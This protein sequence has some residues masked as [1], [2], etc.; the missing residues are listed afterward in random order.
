MHAYIWN[1]WDSDIR[2]QTWDKM[3]NRNACTNCKNGQAIQQFSVCFFFLMLTKEATSFLHLLVFC[4]MSAPDNHT[5]EDL[6]QPGHRGPLCTFLAETLHHHSSP[7]SS[8][9]S[10]GV[11]QELIG[12]PSQLAQESTVDQMSH[13]PRT[14]LLAFR[15][16]DSG[17]MGHTMW[18]MY[19][20][21]LDMLFVLCKGWQTGWSIFETHGRRL[22]S[23]HF[24]SV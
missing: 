7:I 18:R 16:K 11:K 6:C 3:I 8:V 20:M 17:F 9:S 23:F 22:V 15:W 19:F 14:A 5:L 13:L 1:R 24:R 21:R 12:A 10:R 4:T 2:N